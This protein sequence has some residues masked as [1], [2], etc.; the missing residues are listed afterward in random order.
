MVAS[1]VVLAVP[2]VLSVKKRTV[3]LT[4]VQQPARVRGVSLPLPDLR[5]SRPIDGIDVAQYQNFWNDWTLVTVRFRKDNGEQR[6]VYANRVAAQAMRA[7][8]SAYPDGAMFGKVAFTTEVDSSFPNSVEP[9]NFSR[10]QLMR[11]D[12][13]RYK[14]TDGWGYALILPRSTGLS[15]ADRATAGAC[16]ACHKLVPERNFVFSR[17]SFPT[18]PRSQHAHSIDFRSHFSVQTARNLSD[19]ERRALKNVVRNEAISD[20]GP[21]RSA[22]MTLFTGSVNES[23]GV[24]SRYASQDRQVYALWDEK[25]GHFAV[26]RPLAASAECETKEWVALTI[27]DGGARDRPGVPVK[28]GIMCNGVWHSNGSI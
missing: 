24:L 27:T 16:H 13:K 5:N 8:S 1:L 22:S 20:L 25:H 21:I 26:A 19:F 10:I 3:A 6:F 17:L 23:L 4:P 28:V 9:R 12:A 7:G 14:D 2:A 15:V 18:K 11:K